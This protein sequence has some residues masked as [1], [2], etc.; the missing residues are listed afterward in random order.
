MKLNKLK[1][2]LM[3]KLKK[4]IENQKQIENMEIE[5]KK[6]IEIKSLNEKDIEQ[7][8]TKSQNVENIEQVQIGLSQESAKSKEILGNEYPWYYYKALYDNHDPFAYFQIKSN[9]SQIDYNKV[10][11]NANF[12][13]ETKRG[14]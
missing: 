5:T 10:N 7:F 1:L 3:K 9:Q 13:T 8:E 11:Y 2:L 14:K 6:E 12:W 4:E